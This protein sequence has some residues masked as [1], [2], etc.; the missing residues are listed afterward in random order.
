MSLRE[1]SDPFDLPQFVGLIAVNA[2]CIKPLFSTSVWLGSSRGNS[3]KGKKQ[4]S[5]GGSGNYGMSVLG[6]SKSDQR[7]TKTATRLTENGSE[8]MILQDHP[9]DRQGNLGFWNDVSIGGDSETSGPKGIQV[10][11]TYEVTQVEEGKGPMS[12]R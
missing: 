3:S 4:Y 12:G 8:E 10:T 7:N 5:V 2:P 6:M 11:T 1:D 9:H